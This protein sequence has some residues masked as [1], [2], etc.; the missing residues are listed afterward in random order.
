MP[1][2]PGGT[3]HTE[4]AAV[5]DG[6][7]VIW[8]RRRQASELSERRGRSHPPHGGDWLLRVLPGRGGS[9]TGGDI[10]QVADD[11][12]GTEGRVWEPPSLP[13]QSTGRD[14]GRTAAVAA[15]QFAPLRNRTTAQIVLPHENALPHKP[16]YRTKLRN[17]TTAP[18]C[19]TA[20]PHSLHVG[21]GGRTSGR[22]HRGVSEPSRRRRFSADPGPGPG[23]GRSDNAA[24][25]RG[26]SRGPGETFQ[27]GG[28]EGAGVAAGADAAKLRTHHAAE[29][30]GFAAVDQRTGGRTAQQRTEREHTAAGPPREPTR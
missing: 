16:H 18:N 20:L 24:S 3:V 9:G 7:T 22:R 11:W 27:T 19:T 13:R 15:E 14:H 30:A 5:S 26:R 2:P 29:A 25:V 17:R 1:S 12:A 28:L 10:R 21:G 8:R 23:P 6:W 4:V